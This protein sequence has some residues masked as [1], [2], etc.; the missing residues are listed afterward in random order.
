MTGFPP[1]K[2]TL[3]T[4]CG[5]PCGLSVGRYVNQHGILHSKC[6]WL[7]RRPEL[8]D[9]YRWGLRLPCSYHTWIP[10]QEPIDATG[11]VVIISVPSVWRAQAASNSSDLVEW[12]WI[13]ISNSPWKYIHVKYNF[14]KLSLE[15]L[16]LPWS[17]QTHTVPDWIIAPG[18]PAETWQFDSQNSV[19]TDE[20]D[21]AYPKM[22]ER[23]RD[24]Q[25]CLH[26]FC[27]QAHGKKNVHDSVN[28]YSL[29]FIVFHDI[30]IYVSTLCYLFP[31]NS[32]IPIGL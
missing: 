24:S 19:Q 3:V 15:M 25:G 13:C 27:F 5:G 32:N 10:C 8:H 30:S 22:R 7:A 6:G 4:S 28:V 31:F 16:R 23:E 11:N 1:Q 26:K 29:S 21:Q 2:K 9:C 18:L 12:P 17:W 14:H 20:P